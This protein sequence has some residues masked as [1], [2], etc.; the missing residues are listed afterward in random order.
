MS[1]RSSLFAPLPRLGFAPRGRS[2][3]VAPWPISVFLAWDARHRMRRHLETL[4]DSAIT[5]LGLTSD[6]RRRECAKPMWQA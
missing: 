5:D 4:P 1:A 3:D 2:R 6:D